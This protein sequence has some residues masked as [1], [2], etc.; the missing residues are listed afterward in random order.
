VDP[1]T[2]GTTTT[3]MEAPKIPADEPER[4]AALR[5]LALLD[6]PRSETFD[7]ITRLA[8]SA[9]RAPI[10]LISLVDEH[11]QWFKSRVG[12][13]LS[14]TS[15]DVSFCTHVVAQR[16]PMCIEDATRDARF[17]DSPLVVGPTH[18][19]AYLG[20][21]LFT[22]QGHVLGTL[23]A[24]DTVARQFS[25]ADVDT[26]TGFARIV[27]D[28]IRF[29]EMA[30]R[31]EEFAE[32]GRAQERLFRDTFEQAAV[33]I[34][35][36]APS[37]RP[38]RVN[39][40][41]R[42]LLGYE[43]AE[44]CR[45]TFADITHPDDLATNIHLFKCALTGEIDSY[46]M[47][48]R[49]RRKD[50]SYLW[51]YLSVTQCRKPDGAP[52]FM[53]A[54]IEDISETKRSEAE[55]TSSRDGLAGE[56]AAQTRELQ[57]RNA[58]LE[59]LC[60]QAEQS[61][62][63]QHQAEHHLR[64]IANSVPAVIGY[65]NKELR[66]EFAN[67]AYQTW[68]HRAPESI[69]GMNM[70]DLLGTEVFEFMKPYIDGV[71]G[72]QA[73][74]FE[75]K[76]LNPDGSFQY[77]DG[78]YLPDFDEVGAVRGFFVLVTDIT[79]SRT[80]SEHALKLAAAKTEFLANMSHEI[81]TPLNGVLGLTNL[82]LET[83]LSPEQRDF[84]TD[85]RNCGEHLLAVINDILDFSKIDSGNLALEEIDFDLQELV[86]RS[87]AVISPEAAQK[88]L[89]VDLSVN[90]PTPRRLGDPTRIRQVL[91][92]LM[93]NAV[94]FTASGRIAVEITEDS[95]ADVVF[96]VSDSGIGIAPEQVPGIFDRFAQ[97]D[98]STTR[99]F[100]GSGLGLTIAQR[101]VRLMGGDI[102]VDSELG[103]GSR[104]SFRIALARAEKSQPLLT[105]VQENLPA[106]LPG[107]KVLVAED[108]RVNQ[109]LVRR[110]LQTLGCHVT[111]AETGTAVLEHWS[112][113]A[114]DVILMDC[115]MPE[116]DGIEATRL[117]RGRDARGATV[118]IIA[119]TASAMQSDRDQALLAG[120]TDFLTKPLIP[121]ALEAALLQVKRAGGERGA[122][123]STDA[124]D[125]AAA[126]GAPTLS[127]AVER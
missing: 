70:Q 98:T 73:Q 33:G 96:T 65:W 81:R 4:L 69:V 126:D 47:E 51:T 16:K 26:M 48:K 15:R 115:Q 40:R 113:E 45:M 46:R 67:Q 41:A 122:H 118:P 72:G 9:V 84:A 86:E 103:R 117:I 31:T 83:Q 90:L 66:C 63:E 49:F 19:R 17:A 38:I 125:A 107:L 30:Q 7:R 119:L 114:F 62:R 35:H 88:G 61:A 55:L 53:I 75:R 111:V 39:R 44:L 68:T 91:M 36:T 21:P 108:N 59:A 13:D 100:G 14:E 101:L 106:A 20:I 116:M 87:V 6:T 60:R 78:R 120:M 80:A 104:F 50:G 99:R 95:F 82:L 127:S 3:I 8:A 29:R 32:F 27:E 23:C 10:L 74:R 110:M 64:T 18:F 24:I 109:L 97:A 52:D 1:L 105:P 42:D 5:R 94:K 77:R 37:G 12:L 71:L 79:E 2:I 56:V 25:T 58:E 121:G 93:G 102:A 22:T 76:V 43:E 57:R 92:N 124:P 112:R 89:G 123:R 85:T 54:V 28:L 34:I 11:R